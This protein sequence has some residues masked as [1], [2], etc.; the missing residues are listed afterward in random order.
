MLVERPFDGTVAMHHGDVDTESENPSTF[1][2][3]LTL[4]NTVCLLLIF[5]LLFL[6]EE[7]ALFLPNF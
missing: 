6:K 1:D 4:P 7:Y 3:P 2:G 5:I